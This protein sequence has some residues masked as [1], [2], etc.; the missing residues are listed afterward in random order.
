MS[1]TALTR[2]RK[3]TADYEAAAT[4]LLA[5]MSRLDEQMDAD[6]ARGERL[7]AET[8]I[9]KERTAAVLARLQEQIGALSRAA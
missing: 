3:T 8:Q 1:G 9:I 2:K 7:K 5:E 4:Q 6:R